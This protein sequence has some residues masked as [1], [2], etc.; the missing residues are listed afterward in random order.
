MLYELILIINIRV[1]ESTL[2]LAT[3]PRYIELSEK[4]LQLKP[5]HLVI[6]FSKFWQAENHKPSCTFNPGKRKEKKALLLPAGLHSH[7]HVDLLCCWFCCCC[8][9]I[10]SLILQPN[11]KLPKWTKRRVPLEILQ[12][13]RTRED[14]W[15]TQPCGAHNYWILHHSSVRQ[16]LL[17]FPDCISQAN[18][19]N[20]LSVSFHSLS[21]VS[22]RTP[23]K[24]IVLINVSGI[25]CSWQVEYFLLR[26]Q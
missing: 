1:K 20:H 7:W 13:Y 5:L 17:N 23:I 18:L 11:F 19:S 16:P 25:P 15:C 9:C 26:L 6:L 2:A 12:S 21:S 22:L 8:R 10:P 24:Q 14:C 3:L 4:L